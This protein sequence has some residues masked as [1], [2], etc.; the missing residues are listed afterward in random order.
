MGP[1]AEFRGFRN[2]EVCSYFFTKEIF[3]IKLAYQDGGH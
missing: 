1:K 3:K 2:A